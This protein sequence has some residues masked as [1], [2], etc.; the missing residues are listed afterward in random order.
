VR[1][2]LTLVLAAGLFAAARLGSAWIAL[3]QGSTDTTR[4]ITWPDKAS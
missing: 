2:I 4:V 3:P 1:K